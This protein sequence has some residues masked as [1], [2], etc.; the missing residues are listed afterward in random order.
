MSQTHQTRLEFT[1]LD[2]GG[3]IAHLILNR[4]EQANAF[5]AQMMEEV[6]E[7]A[8]ALSTLADLRLL[9]LSGAGKHFSAG[10]DLG[11]MKS[12]AELS[13]SFGLPTRMKVPRRGSPHSWQ[14]P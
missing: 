3:R 10:A 14:Q 11:W 4:P 2:Q 13:N 6:T 8:V 9:I 1:S 5:S 12:S 7:H